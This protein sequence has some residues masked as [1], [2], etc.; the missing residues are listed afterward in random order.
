MYN[1]FE[2][3]KQCRQIEQML[4]DYTAHRLPE[5]IYEKVEAHLALCD[6]CQRTLHST[7]SA[8]QLI[9]AARSR[10]IPEPVSTWE[11]LA[12]QLQRFPV[13]VQNSP[14]YA[15]L[16]WSLTGGVAAA[17]LI[18][19]A[20]LPM[21]GALQP[22][23][24]PVLAL[25]PAESKSAPA[26][27]NKPVVLASKTTEHAPAT[28]HASLQQLPR[29]ELAAA[30]RA[31]F[32]A[33]AASTHPVVL[34]QAAAR[35]PLHKHS[36]PAVSPHAAPHTAKQPRI[37]LPQNSPS[38]QLQYVSASS[39]EPHYVLSMLQPDTSSEDSPY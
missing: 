31:A 9:S 22:V 4:W 27:I 39:T 19:L 23:V 18:L 15:P 20:F 35:T 3:K 14:R 13:P 5:D 32:T 30:C 11:D 34:T 24:H 2:H 29:T 26:V 1:F 6:S 25:H 38:N 37:Q 21:I 12:P 33:L 7:R 17:L 36:A 16:V 28:H 8:H 10:E